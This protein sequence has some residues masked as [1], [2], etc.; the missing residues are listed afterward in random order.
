MSKYQVT[1][2]YTFIIDGA[3]NE[4]Y[5]ESRAL[6]EVDSDPYEYSDIEI[7]EIHTSKCCGLRAQTPVVDDGI[8]SD[9]AK[10]YIETLKSFKDYLEEHKIQQEKILNALREKLGEEEK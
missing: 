1:L 4:S 2:T 10:D 9:V 6:Q 3:K 5:A 8:N 7:K